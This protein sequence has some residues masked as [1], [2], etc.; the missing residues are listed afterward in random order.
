MGIL[1]GLLEQAGGNIDLDALAS[2][3]GL[4]TE[5]LRAGA[6][7]MLGQLAGTGTDDPDEAASEAAA[8]TGAPADRLRQLLPQL[9]QQLGLGQG[10]GEGG[11]DLGG[12]LDQAKG[13]LDRDGDGNPLD[14]LA[15]MARGLFGRD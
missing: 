1:D 10:G 5:Q 13:F 3:V 12:L 2:R 6:E 11:A 14:D 15:G 9:T 8:Q 4:S 7:S